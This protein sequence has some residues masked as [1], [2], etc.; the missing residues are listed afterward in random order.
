MLSTSNPI[1]LV[2]ALLLLPRANA[3][4]FHETLSNLVARQTVDCLGTASCTF[5]SNAIAGGIE[6]CPIASCFCTTRFAAN[7]ELCTSCI[8]ADPATSQ[9]NISSWSEVIS[10]Y[11]TACD[12]YGV[13]TAPATST[14]R[15]A[16]TRTVTRTATRT[17]TSTRTATT[18]VFGA[19]VAGDFAGARSSGGA[20]S[21]RLIAGFSELGRFGTT[22]LTIA[23]ALVL[24][25]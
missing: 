23:L 10:S 6:A 7:L 9:E 16:V 1:F 4:P 20:A 25:M 24:V 19:G 21:G 8:F 15:A 3:S 5:I 14:G 18:T 2:C 12:G 13:P 22:S 11:N 17:V